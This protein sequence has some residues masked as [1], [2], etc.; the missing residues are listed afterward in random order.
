[1]SGL[2][3]LWR[4]GDSRFRGS[5]LADQDVLSERHVADEAAKKCWRK[6][7]LIDICTAFHGQLAV[8]AL[9]VAP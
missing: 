9:A 5:R 8:G 6:F 3:R 7:D 2:M 4:P 1:L